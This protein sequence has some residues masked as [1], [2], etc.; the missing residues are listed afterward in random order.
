V[1]AKTLGEIMSKNESSKIILA[2]D[3]DPIILNAYN[4]ALKEDYKI[5][6]VPTA[7]EMSDF[8]ELTIPDLILLDTSMPPNIDGFEALTKL[9]AD[10]KSANIK[11]IML[12]G[13]TSDE[14]EVQALSNGAVDYIRKPFNPTVLR[15]RIEL[16]LE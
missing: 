9:K 4:A 6:A 2:V 3:D 15:L 5:H 12:S 7:E 16:R 8:L 10:P 13:D 1:Q 14:D 11:V